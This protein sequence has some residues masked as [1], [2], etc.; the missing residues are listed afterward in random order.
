MMCE[1]TDHPERSSEKLKKSV[2]NLC[3]ALQRKIKAL[4]V[5][6]QTVNL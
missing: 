6:V 5:R 3:T 1:A 4:V 2:F